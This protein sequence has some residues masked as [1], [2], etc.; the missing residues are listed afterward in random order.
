LFTPK[1]FEL[2]LQND[3]KNEYIV[4]NVNKMRYTTKKKQQSKRIQ[5][6]P[7]NGKIQ[8]K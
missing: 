2:T 6:I 3:Q 1:N 4:K 5:L 8:T 7:R